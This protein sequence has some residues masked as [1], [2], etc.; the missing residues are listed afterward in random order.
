[1]DE[2]IEALMMFM[3]DAS[4]ETKRA[5]EAKFARANSLLADYQA[6]RSRCLQSQS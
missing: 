1:M 2:S 4:E 6:A 3:R 5:T